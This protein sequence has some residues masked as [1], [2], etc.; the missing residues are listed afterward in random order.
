MPRYS[1]QPQQGVGI[2]YTP[3]Y[4]PGFYEAAGNMLQ[5]AQQQ[6]DVTTAA[7]AENMAQYGQE[8]SFAPE[9]KEQTLDQY[10]Q[11]LASIVED[12]GGDVG[13]ARNKI[14]SR[15]GREAAN[16]FWQANRYQVEQAKRFQNLVDQ[17][18]PD[19]IVRKDPRSAEALQQALSS[20]DI[21]ALDADV[22]KASDYVG[23]I[24]R[25]GQDIKPHL[26][27]FGISEANWDGFLRTGSREYIDDATLKRLA[28]EILPAFRAAAPTWNI[29]NRSGYEFLQDDQ[30]TVDFIRSVWSGKQMERTQLQH[31]QDPTYQAPGVGDDPFGGML[32]GRSRFQGA[33]V[34]ENTRKIERGYEKIS[35]DVSTISKLRADLSRGEAKEFSMPSTAKEASSFIQDLDGQELNEVLEILYPTGVSPF[36]MRNP[37]TGLL[38]INNQYIR[39]GGSDPV[40]AIDG[41]A[42]DVVSLE[43]Q[44][45]S[46]QNRIDRLQNRVNEF[47]SENLAVQ[48]LISEFG[49]TQETI[50]NNPEEFNKILDKVKDFEIAQAVQHHREI[51]VPSK[52]AEAGILRSL[53]SSERG[54]IGRTEHVSTRRSGRE[55]QRESRGGLDLIRNAKDSDIQNI[56]LIPSTGEYKITVKDGNTT[57]RVYIPIT[58]S[59]VVAYGEEQTMQSGQVILE[60]LR[61]LN[62]PLNELLEEPI[63]VAGLYFNHAKLTD[64]DGNIIPFLG[65][66]VGG[67]PQDINSYRRVDTGFLGNHIFNAI[68]M[69]S[70]YRADIRSKVVDSYRK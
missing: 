49:F 42:K 4:D 17:F 37:D 32:G 63:E 7:K 13:A 31:M 27:A 47:I 66:Y 18:G 33:S 60:G 1:R 22:V 65:I 28:T 51:E 45:V 29:D 36:I 59:G 69:G 23:T 39:S 25:L 3:H 50:I 70:A 20:G 30:A 21:G 56:E 24:Q 67:D 52:E 53:R 41:I 62:T 26:Q 57:K 35:N 11:D 14:V 64:D 10:R 9:L 38:E 68:T 19:A 6:Y 44:T 5:Q 43:G 34:E 2:A 15:M 16:P 46:V 58:E 12:Y 8:F 55:R 61:N 48:D 54:N 40:H